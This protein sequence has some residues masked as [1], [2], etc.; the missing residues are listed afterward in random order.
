MKR[1]LALLFVVFLFTPVHADTI[2]TP[3]LWHVQ[4]RGGDVY[5]LGSVHILPPDMQWRSPAIRAALKRT[6]IFVFE[7]PQDEKSIAQLQQM[8]AARGYLPPGQSLRALLRPALRPDYD[9]AVA[10]SGLPPSA[11]ETMRPWLAALQIMFA[12]IAKQNFSAENGVDSQLAGEAAR[13][14]KTVRYLETIEQQFALLAPDDRTLEMEEFEAGLKDLSDVVA[15][16]QPMVVAWS[17]G[18]VEALDELING[19]LDKF[20]AARKA[21]LDDRNRAWLPKVQAMLGEKRTFFIAV[22]AGHLT[23]AQ[24][25][26]NLLRRAGYKVEGP[27]GS[28]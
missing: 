18:D 17:K 13:T 7:V 2:A 19:E 25:L 9:A 8:I 10:A 12:Q 28:Q 4:G 5:L 16:V 20:P 26:P 6:D 1:F 21:L 22:G 24:G 3:A 15:G 27:K 11:I 23:G 14:G